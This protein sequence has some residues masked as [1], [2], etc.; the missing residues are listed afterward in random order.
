MKCVNNIH[1]LDPKTHPTE[2]RSGWEKETYATGGQNPSGTPAYCGC[3]S[4]P[5]KGKV[6]CSNAKFWLIYQSEVVSVI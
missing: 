6:S 2:G 5:A 4:R 1:V 3:N